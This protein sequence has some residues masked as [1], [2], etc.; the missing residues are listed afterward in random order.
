[1]ALGMATHKARGIRVAS[2]T[3]M[4]D[5]FIPVDVWQYRLHFANYGSYGNAFVLSLPF[6][7]AYIRGAV[8]PLC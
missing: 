4:Y 5:A 8:L 6:R 2:Q 1:M 7:L 3:R